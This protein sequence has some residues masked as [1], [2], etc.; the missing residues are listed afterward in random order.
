MKKA[1]MAVC[2]LCLKLTACNNNGIISETGDTYFDSEKNTDYT[3]EPE[4]LHEKI[5]IPAPDID[6]VTHIIAS[7]GGDPDIESETIP[8]NI[9]YYTL[10]A[11][12]SGEA[13]AFYVDIDGDA[14]REFCLVTDSWHGSCMCVC[15]YID[16]SGW[17]IS[18]S[19]TI[20]K[21]HTYLME[22][23]NGGTYLFAAVGVRPM[24]GLKSFI[25]KDGI[26]NEFELVNIDDIDGYDDA[27]YHKRI[28]EAI[29]DYSGLTDLYKDY[30]MAY[31][32]DVYTFYWYL[33]GINN[34]TNAEY[35][36][37]AE[38]FMDQI[39]MLFEN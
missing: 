27:G 39:N 32:E 37:A 17:V 25:Y 15:E 11:S 26:V 36:L 21:K 8:E 22:D 7:W 13:S 34:V 4:E 31:T 28:N 14:Q 23:E 24:E 9:D 33:A 18:D 2:L 12:P 16:E 38:K 35:E 3:A 20:S 19:L 6:F 1:I 5:N 29:K 10:G 30:P